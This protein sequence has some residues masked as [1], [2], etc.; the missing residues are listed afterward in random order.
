MRKA[1]L[2]QNRAWTAEEY[3]SGIE[4]TKLPSD[5]TQYVI[6]GGEGFICFQVARE[7]ARQASRNAIRVSCRNVVLVGNKAVVTELRELAR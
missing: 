4:S 1:G 2:G 3:G 7:R 5:E 6:R